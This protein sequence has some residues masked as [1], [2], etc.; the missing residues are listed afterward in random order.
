MIYN[1]VVLIHNHQHTDLF[2]PLIRYQGLGINEIRKF[3]DE[4]YPHVYEYLPEPSL[5]LPKVSKQWLANVC[6]TILEDKFS[7]WVKEKCDARHEKLAV[8]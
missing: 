8:K 3:L 7:K 4:T 2:L 6:A 5:E 1:L